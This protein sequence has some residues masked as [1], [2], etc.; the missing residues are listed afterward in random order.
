MPNRKINSVEDFLMDAGGYMEI[1]KKLNVS[2]PAITKWKERGIPQEHWRAIIKIWN[3]TPGELY[4]IT[5]KAKDAH[6]K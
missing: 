3:L 5:Q 6:G 2:Y 4:H 1:A